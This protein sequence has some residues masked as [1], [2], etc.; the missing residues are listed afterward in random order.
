MLKEILSIVFGLLIIAGIV[1]VFVRISM[2]IRRGGGSPETASLLGSLYIVQDRDG[3]RAI[4][5]IVEVKAEKKLEEEE[6]GEDKD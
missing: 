2:R 4:E 5:D 1:A 6:S 3:R